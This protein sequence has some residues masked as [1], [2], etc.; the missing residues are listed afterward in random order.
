[1]RGTGRGEQAQQPSDGAKR[2][3]GFFAKTRIEIL[4]QKNREL[5]ARLEQI[6]AIAAS[7]VP[8][9]GDAAVPEQPRAKIEAKPVRP[10][11]V[12]TP[13]SSPR[14]YAAVASDDSIHPAGRK[15]L[16]ALARHAPE[17]FT[18][19]QAATLA[20]LKPSG[21]HFNAGRKSSRESGYIEEVN[22]LLSASA[23]G[24]KAAG[25]VPP[26]AEELAAAMGKKLSGGYWNSRV[27]VLRNN[28]LIETD[29]RRYRS[30]ALFR[31]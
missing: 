30:A 17:R 10:L 12:V 18:W 27:A 5:S 11:R 19:G 3:P 2:S 13:G 22:D 26:A 8:A 14:G 28:G 20:G 1:V 6:A 25:A 4:E 23:I 9:A 24:L 15:L 29:G 16:T 21:G 31:K 7:P